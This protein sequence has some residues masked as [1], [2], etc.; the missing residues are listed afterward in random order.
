MLCF[1]L[2]GRTRRM[3]S[4]SHFDT[5]GFKSL[6]RNFDLPI[7][8]ICSLV[9]SSA[10]SLVIFLRTR[11]GAGSKLSTEDTD[12]VSCWS[13]EGVDIFLG[14]PLCKTLGRSLERIFVLFRAALVGTNPQRRRQT[15]CETD[16]EFLV[17]Y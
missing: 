8:P 15:N 6:S 14:R 12:S 2:G 4:V 3:G 16:V 1:I 9:C 17:P 5:A 11:V 7:L 10:S 13:R